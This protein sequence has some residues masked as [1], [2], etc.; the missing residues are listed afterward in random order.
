MVA[1]APWTYAA[2]TRAGTCLCQGVPARGS[3]QPAEVRSLVGTPVSTGRPY[4]SGARRRTARAETHGS[5]RPSARPAAPAARR[6]SPGSR[7]RSSC[8]RGWA[9]GR[10]RGSPAALEP[11]LSELL[12][13]NNFSTLGDPTRAAGELVGPRS[14]ATR[15]ICTQ[16]QQQP[17]EQWHF[18]SDRWR[19]S[20]NVHDDQHPRA[21]M[22]VCPFRTNPCPGP[23]PPNCERVDPVE[24]RG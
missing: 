14:G 11:T 3:R 1:G 16:S 4:S 24:D 5:C 22:S 8:R 13:S 23:A 2:S 15:P 21:T 19:E 12:E 6:A 17:Y 7:A 9:K 10:G 18:S 20:G